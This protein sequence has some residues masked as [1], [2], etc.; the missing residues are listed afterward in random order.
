MANGAQIPFWIFFG[1]DG[2]VEGGGINQFNG[3]Y[4][5]YGNY[6]IYIQIQSGTEIYDPTGWEE[7]LLGALGNSTEYWVEYLGRQ[8]RIYYDLNRK[9]LQFILAQ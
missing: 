4:G 3:R 8:M 9:Y 2:Q 7:R 6:D 5:L 1:G